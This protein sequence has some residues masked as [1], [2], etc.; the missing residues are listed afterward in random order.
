MKTLFVICEV[1]RKKI[2][3]IF[4]I[5]LPVNFFDYISV[6]ELGILINSLFLALNIVLTSHISYGHLV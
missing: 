4:L 1:L 6:F 2:L 5:K 3:I